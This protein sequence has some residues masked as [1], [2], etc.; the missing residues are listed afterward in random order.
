[1]HLIEHLEGHHLLLKCWGMSVHR[2]AFS[3]VDVFLFTPVIFMVLVYCW[4][5]SWIRLLPVS[6]AS[7]DVNLHPDGYYD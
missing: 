3:F 1:M 6:L 4:E 7:P 2:T 5:N